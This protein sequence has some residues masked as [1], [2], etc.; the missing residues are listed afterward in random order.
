MTVNTDVEHALAGPLQ[1][2]R[3]VPLRV[4]AYMRIADAIRSGV[5]PRASLLPS[6][7]DLG[8]LMGVSR[9]VVREALIFLE[10]DGLVRSRRG[11]GRFVADQLPQVG[12][13]QVQPIE[14]LL[15][16]G[17]P[18]TVE[19]TEH[20]LQEHSASFIADELGIPETEPSWF[21]ESRVHREGQ[22]VALVHE[23]LPA[24]ERLDRFGDGVRE[25][26]EHVPADQTVLAALKSRGTL[27]GPGSTDITVGAAGEARGTLMGLSAREP[28]LVLTRHLRLGDAPLYV[29][30]IL[31]N[32][33]QAQVTVTHAA[34]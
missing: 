17:G 14:L 6:E 15:G 23:H 30:K 12:L 5:L 34:P 4:A 2:A 3:G 21:F 26:V 1:Q 27:L 19:R 33:H 9:T 32:P 16:N 29:S 24:G 25:V 8:G 28:V 11:I 18:A 20:H 31:I 22:V 10:E 13:Q 7:A